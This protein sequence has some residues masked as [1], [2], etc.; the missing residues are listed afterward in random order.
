MQIEKK[1]RSGA[2]MLVAMAFLSAC[3]G[4]QP[5]SRTTTG[6]SAGESLPPALLNAEYK[7]I[8]DAPVR[9]TDGRY[10]GPPFAPGGASRPTLVLETDRFA[11]G[12]LDGDGTDELA[13]LLAQSSGGSGTFIYMAVMREGGG[14][15]SNMET[16]LLG[17]RVQV[18]SL[19]IQGGTVAVSMLEHGPEDAAC[20]PTQGVLRVWQ[21]HEERLREMK[22]LRGQL[23]YGHESRTFA[24]CAKGGPLWVVDG[25]NGDLPEVYDGLAIQ[26][27]EPVFVEVR[28]LLIP[29]PGSGFAADYEGQIR[30]L[31]LYRA[32]R[33]GPAC[34]EDLRGVA[35]RAIG[36]EPFWRLDITPEGLELRRLGSENRSFQ[37]EVTSESATELVWSGL[38]EDGSG[39]EAAIRPRRC[40]DPMSG[41]VFPLTA[42]VTV[43]GTTLTGCAMAGDP[44]G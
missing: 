15:L 22:I 29:E 16:V 9:L 13:A 12:D 41:S 34:G 33:E 20:C 38:G 19:D 30:V 31:E 36:V 18:S 39:L 6:D 27:Y 32:A 25:T 17:D 42:K 44:P 3:T 14:G 23:V 21:V 11:R 10:E 2:L 8:F 37:V 43:D 26:P 1:Q 5:A 35:F 4:G 24:P 28:A 40:V 7:G